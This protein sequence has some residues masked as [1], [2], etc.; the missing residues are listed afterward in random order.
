MLHVITR[1]SLDTGFGSIG[2]FVRMV[3]TRKYE[4]MENVSL[5]LLC[6]ERKSMGFVRRFPGFTHLSF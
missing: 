3:I 5:T 2:A 6:G 1:Y 4:V